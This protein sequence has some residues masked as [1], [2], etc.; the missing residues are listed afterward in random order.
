MKITKVSGELHHVPVHREMHDA[1]REF[2]ILDLVLG[3]RDG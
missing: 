1:V 2:S 3:R